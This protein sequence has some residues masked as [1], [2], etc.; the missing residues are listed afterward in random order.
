MYWWS[1][2]AAKLALS[3]E[4]LGS[5]QLLPYVLVFSILETGVLEFSFFGEPSQDFGVRRW[6]LGSLSIL[7]TAFGCYYVYRQN[8]GAKGERF[9]ERF[10]VLG[11]ITGIR[12]M[13]FMFL[14]IM[15]FYGIAAVLPSIGSGVGADVVFELASPIFYLYL[16]HHVGNLA[17]SVQ[18]A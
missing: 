18:A 3:G 12:Y 4:P 1:L 6:L 11:W 2:R 15:V 7:L 13:V 17:R 8:G 16:G 9:L 10:L 5:R 14:G